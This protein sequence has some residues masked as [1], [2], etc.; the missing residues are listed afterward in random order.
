MLSLV[1]IFLGAGFATHGIGFS[2]ELLKLGSEFS[3]LASIA[4][5]KCEV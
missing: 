1:Y 3:L 5:D 4:N 2:Y